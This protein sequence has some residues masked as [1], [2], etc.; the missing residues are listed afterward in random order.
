VEADGYLFLTLKT[1]V[2]EDVDVD[3]LLVSIELRSKVIFKY[4]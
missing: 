1:T 2:S 3:G 4:F